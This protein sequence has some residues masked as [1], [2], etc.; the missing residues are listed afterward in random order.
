MRRKEGGVAMLM[1]AL[2]ALPLILSFLAYMIN[3]KW[4]AWSVLPLPVW[5]RWLEAASMKLNEFSSSELEN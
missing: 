3:P 1:R 5:T 2:I 4:M